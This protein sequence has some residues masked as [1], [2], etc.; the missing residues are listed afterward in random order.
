M[1]GWDFIEKTFNAVLSLKDGLL[2][3]LNY[4][5]SVLGLDLSVWQLFSGVGIV[6]VLVA[7]LVKA[8]L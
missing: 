3:F 7:V 4:E 2:T 1:N 6:T 8:I 5:I